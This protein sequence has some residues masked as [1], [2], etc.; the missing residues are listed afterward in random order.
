MENPT[1]FG[2]LLLLTFYLGIMMFVMGTFIFIF[3]ICKYRKNKK[4]SIIKTIS[5]VC[6]QFLASIILS[7]IIW[8]FWLFNV[9]VMI[10]V[11]LIPSLFAEIITILI[12]YYFKNWIIE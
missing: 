11:I 4:K 10:G 8:K 5:F 9:D 1:S 6:I 3:L 7:I 12:F 2:E